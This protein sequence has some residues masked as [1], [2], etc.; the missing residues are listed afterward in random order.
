[1]RPESLALGGEGT[2]ARVESS[3]FEG[4][5]WIHRLCVDGTELRAL[6]P[7]PFAAG[8]TVRVRL[9]GE[10]RVLAEEG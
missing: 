9:A 7:R 8:E 2:P 4:G 5:S 1:V 3:A 6:A 10:A